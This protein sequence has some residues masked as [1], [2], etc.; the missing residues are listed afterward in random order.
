MNMKKETLWEAIGQIDDDLIAEAGSWQKKCRTSYRPWVLTAACLT[1]FVM[2]ALPAVLSL[3]SPSTPEIALSSTDWAE[4]PSIL[5]QGKQYYPCSDDDYQK[6][7]LSAEVSLAQIGDFL[8]TVPQNG[9]EIYTYLPTR[10]DAV[11]AVKE[12]DSYTL[13][14]FSSFASYNQNQ[15]ENAAAYLELYGIHSANDIK[16]ITIDSAVL[17]SEEVK[18]FYQFFSVLQNDS[19]AYFDALTAPEQNISSAL[20]DTSNT[21][22]Q[23]GTNALSRSHRIVIY[24]NNGLFFETDYY[25][26]IQFISRHKVEPNFQR[27]LTD[28]LT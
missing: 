19:D 2:A 26:N 25:P 7:E 27:F 23:S 10:C 1:L 9:K 4:D 20:S 14:T 3:P 6:Y 11:I 21:P 12:E 16:K 22:S 8:G 18:T 24:A 13:Y 28:C 15:D 17:S 5:F